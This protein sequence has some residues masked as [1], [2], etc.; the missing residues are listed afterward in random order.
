MNIL[1][2]AMMVSGEGK[3]IVY[4]TDTIEYEGNF[5]IVPKW[6]ESPDLPYKMP[7]RI[8]CLDNLPHQKV[9]PNLPYS[10]C[11]LNPIPRG[12]LY[13]PIPSSLIGEYIVKIRPNIKVPI[14]K[15][16]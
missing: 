15:I 14:P 11:L 2:T 16:H 13:D 12:I 5:W 1:K 6:L 7:E 9:E 4:Y 8:I 3:A 10:F